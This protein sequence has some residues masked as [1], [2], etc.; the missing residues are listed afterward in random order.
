[1]WQEQRQEGKSIS[2]EFQ[3]VMGARSS[4]LIDHLKDLTLL[5]ISGGLWIE[6]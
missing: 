5:C 6:N 1:M 2:V 4:A 3:K